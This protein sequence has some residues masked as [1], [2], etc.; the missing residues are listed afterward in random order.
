M[1]GAVKSIVTRTTSRT[2]SRILSGSPWTAKKIGRVIRRVTFPRTPIDNDE[3]PTS[4]EDAK[5]GCA[6]RPADGKGIDA[7]IQVAQEVNRE[8][9]DAKRQ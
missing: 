5:F 4:V 6:Q 3:G 8:H 7:V 9:A 2:P 1:A